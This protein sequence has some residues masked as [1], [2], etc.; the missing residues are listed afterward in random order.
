M[1]AGDEPVEVV[2]GDGTVLEVV[3]RAVV[4]AENRRHRNV[5]VALRRHD[6]RVVVHRRADW[7]DVHPAKLDA[8]FGGVPAVGEDDRCAAVRELAEE[9]GLAVAVEDLVDLGAVRAD[10]EHT[11]WVGRLFLVV[12]D[13]PV[14]AA[15]GEV[16]EVWEVT[17]EELSSWLGRDDVCPDTRAA[18]LPVLLEALGA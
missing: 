12:D 10:D 9:A 6:G 17:A 11:R 14:V 13:R 4:R 18:V 2:D 5:A 1:S 15:D 3:T 7:K 16:S 8:V